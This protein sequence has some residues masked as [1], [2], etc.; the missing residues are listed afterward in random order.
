MEKLRSGR[1][2]I[3][4]D[5]RLS[6]RLLA[7]WHHLRSGLSCAMNRLGLSLLVASLACLVGF[8]QSPPPAPGVGSNNRPTA[9]PAARRRIRAFVGEVLTV[10]P[11]ALRF[12]ARESLKD[13]SLKST[14][15]DVDAWT[16]FS[17][18]NG[19]ASFADLHPN[20][21]VIVKY[22]EDHATRRKKAVSV[23]IVPPATTQ[24]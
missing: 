6:D 15:F 16:K 7:G 22:H 14:T 9:A 20:D 18:A 11:K 10:E 2:G 8:R 19:V 4:E 21:H 24:R 12:S 23:T 13:G 3:E 5:N 17:R 1:G